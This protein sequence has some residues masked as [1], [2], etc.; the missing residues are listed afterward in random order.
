M[1]RIL[2]VDD[3]A[4]ITDSLVNLVQTSLEQVDVYPA[5]SAKQALAYVQ[6]A[7][8]DILVTDIQMP[9]MN[10]IELLERVNQILPQCRT[11]F[12]SGHD[13]FDYAY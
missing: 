10:G 2:I 4:T 6:R 12:L 13:D 8:F 11:L 3:E 9:G 5:Y 1:Y 7:G